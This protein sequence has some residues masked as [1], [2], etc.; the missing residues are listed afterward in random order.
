MKRAAALACALALAASA[1]AADVP[2]ACESDP[3]LAQRVANL[4]EQMR[5]I[6]AA[7]G[8]AE[9]RRL[10]DLH[11]KAMQ[12]GLRELRGRGPDEACRLEVMQAVM[13]QMLRHQLALRE[14]AE[15]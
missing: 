13:E 14:S 11:L 7:D 5:R 3:G 1:A 10:M 6:E 2:S 9:Q 8:R 15:R 12:E 4:H